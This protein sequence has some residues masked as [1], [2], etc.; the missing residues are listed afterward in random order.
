MKLLGVIV[1]LLILGLGGWSL[2]GMFAMEDV[3]GPPYSVLSREDGYEVRRYEAFVVAEIASTGFY[4]LALNRGFTALLEYIRGGNLHAERISM[5]RPVLEKSAGEGSR[6]I[7]F[8]LPKEY[9]SEPAPP[10]TNVGIITRTVPSRTV[11]AL[12]FSY[13]D[14]AE[15]VEAKKIELVELLKNDGVVLAGVPEAAYYSAPFVPPFMLKTEIL[16]PIQHVP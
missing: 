13:S 16:V 10:P 12:S 9:V 11:A 1:F 2:Y 4:T 7:A 3:A 15:T 6:V 5:R 8:V 14:S